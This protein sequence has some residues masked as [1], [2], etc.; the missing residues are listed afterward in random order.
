MISHLTFPRMKISGDLAI[1]FR[2]STPL[3]YVTDCLVLLMVQKSGDHH[4]G[5]IEPYKPIGSMYSIFIYL[6][7]NHKNQ[8]F[9]YGKY[10]VRPMDP[11]G[12]N[13]MN[14]PSTRAELIPDFWLLA[15][16]NRSGMINLRAQ[17]GPRNTGGCLELYLD[18]TSLTS[19]WIY[20]G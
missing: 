6:H 12:N 9:M 17:E 13:G 16:L 4:L 10:T 19:S 3:T 15:Y 20:H 5:C 18:I 2:F 8:P 1:S 14:L 7:E 11:L